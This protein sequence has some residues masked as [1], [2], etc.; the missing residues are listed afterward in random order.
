MKEL[1]EREL[2][3]LEILWDIKSGFVN[4]VLDKF[5]DP[6]PPYTTVSSIIRI[7]ESKG[8]VSHKVYGKTHEYSPTISRVKYKKNLLKNVVSK[9][10]EG[11]FDKVVSFMASENELSEEE[12]N[13]IAH[14]IENFKSKKND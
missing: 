11:S 6:K 7:L 13:E 4:D 3:V 12:A 8:Y 10:F 14:L 9:F 2:N 1:T 5:P